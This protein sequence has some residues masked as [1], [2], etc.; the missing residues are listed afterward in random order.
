MPPATAKELKQETQFVEN[1]KAKRKALGR[2]I[3]DQQAR[4]EFQKAKRQK[5]AGGADVSGKRPGILTRAARV[6]RG[7]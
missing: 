4:N 1:L 3:T 2:P 6:S 7:V 5:A